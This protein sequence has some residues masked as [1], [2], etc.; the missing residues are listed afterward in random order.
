MRF[1]T[2]RLLLLKFSYSTDGLAT[3][4]EQ[5]LNDFNDPAVA[6]KSFLTNKV[7]DPLHTF[8][9]AGQTILSQ[10][11]G[12]YFVPRWQTYPVLETSMVN[13]N[14]LENPKVSKS[15]RA[16]I[17]SK[18][19]VLSG[20]H[21][22]PA[23]GPSDPDRNTAFFSTLESMT[24]GKRVEYREDPVSHM[25]IPIFKM[26]NTTDREVI[27]VLKATLHWHD[28]LLG[29]LQENNNGYLVVIENGCDPEGENAFTY[30]LD[31]PNV[32]VVGRGDRHNPK[33]QH[34][35][36]EG[37][38]SNDNME[39]GTVEGLRYDDTS[40]PHVFRVYPT[41][42]EFD[43]YV[44]PMPIII[45]LSISAIFAFTIGMFLLYDRLVERRQRIVLAKATQST[46]IIS[47]L[48]VSHKNRRMLPWNQLGAPPYICFTARIHSQSKSE[49]V[50][51]RWRQKMTINEKETQWSP[52]TRN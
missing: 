42:A 44:T 5:G 17:E 26:L 39:D 32:K 11:K 47:S 33:F 35:L 10:S 14:L 25:T 36:V 51:L 38:F 20:F 1:I 6:R 27:A 41:Q 52:T 18:S 13:E 30:Q 16:S 48:F 12:P 34:Y 23:G 4:E 50:C 8:N 24:E 29:V 37:F 9:E 40:C 22:A 43:K 3:Q 28:Y 21:F 31:G 19:A 46:A 15:V 7:V 2:H 45:S 49:I